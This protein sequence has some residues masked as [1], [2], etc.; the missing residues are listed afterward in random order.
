[1]PTISPEAMVD[2][3]PY[4]MPYLF[5]V[6]IIGT[7]HSKDA[8]DNSGTNNPISAIIT[9]SAVAMAELANAL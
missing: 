5:I 4:L 6:I 8:K 1:M 7:G 2:S 9:D 3:I